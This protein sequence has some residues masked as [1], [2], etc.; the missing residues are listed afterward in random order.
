[1]QFVGGGMIAGHTT[2]PAGTA[3]NQTTATTAA[4]RIVAI[5]I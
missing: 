3:T 2:G 1:M 4:A 5:T